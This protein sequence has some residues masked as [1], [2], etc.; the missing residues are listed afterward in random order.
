MAPLG[1]IAPAADLL[2]WYN[3]VFVTIF[4][5]G[6]F[7]TL[8]QLIGLGGESHVEAHMDADADLDAHVDADMD[9]H[10]DVD[11]DLDGHVDAD[12]D[13]DADGHIDH[14]ADG[15]GE[16]PGDQGVTFGLGSAVAQL[17]GLGK[18]PLSISLMVLCY[19][20]GLAGW[21]SNRV[22]A[23]HFGPP[24]RYFPISLLAALV[25][26]FVV[27]RFV[28]GFMGRYVPSFSTSAVEPRQLVGAT[29]QTVLP[30]NERMGL[31]TLYDRFGTLHTVRCKVSDG[32]GDIGK[33]EKIVLVKYLP[34]RDLYVVGRA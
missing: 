5:V 34:D 24:E 13:A 27:L 17:F 7:F 6:F 30:V 14:D 8:L 29:A 3:A 33:G 22:I 19:T 26:G 16:A 11:H 32:A 1:T 4:G 25:V 9:G 28:S 15:D 18:V 21:I 31:A 23:T 12:G 20:V 10:V 2:I